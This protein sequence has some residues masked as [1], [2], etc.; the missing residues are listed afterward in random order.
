MTDLAT[1]GELIA[2]RRRSL[3]LTQA[4][5]AA[6]AGVGR[7]TLDALENGRSAELGFG[8]VA[9]ILFALGMELHAMERVRRRPTLEELE[10]ENR[11]ADLAHRRATAD[12]A[13]RRAVL[14]TARASAVAKATAGPEALRSQDVLHDEDGLPR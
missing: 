3:K 9:R 6:R 13:A 14:R 2:A 10:E 4:K 5:L 11:I 12:R 8:K 7:V 1:M